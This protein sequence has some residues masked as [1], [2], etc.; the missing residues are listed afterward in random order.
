MAIGAM[1]A[2]EDAGL[3]VPDDVAVVGFDDIDYATLVTPSLT[4]VQQNQ[5]EL[6]SGLVKAMLRLLDHPAE[7]PAVSI[8]PIELVVRES[9]GSEQ[10]I[11]DGSQ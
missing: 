3:R 4:T 11:R 10:A 6:A 9:S 1:A 2:I 5:E 7:P 8:V